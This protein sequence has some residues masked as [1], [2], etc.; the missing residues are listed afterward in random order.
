[1]RRNITG[2]VLNQLKN[3][4]PA[5]GADYGQPSIR[6]LTTASSLVSL[7]A[8]EA[9][10]PPRKEASKADTTGKHTHGMPS[11]AA[12]GDSAGPA[13][14]EQRDERAADN[15]CGALEPRGLSAISARRRSF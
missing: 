5:S 6:I 3:C 12:S 1:M 11:G 9:G 2:P 4:Q 13:N 7:W 14:T 8:G 15:L 10:P